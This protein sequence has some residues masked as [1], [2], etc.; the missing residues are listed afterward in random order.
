MRRDERDGGRGEKK[1]GVREDSISEL[2]FIFGR[3]RRKIRE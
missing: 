1:E 3:K 2:F